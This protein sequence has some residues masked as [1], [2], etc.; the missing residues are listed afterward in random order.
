VFGKAALLSF[1]R[2][3][4]VLYGQTVGGIWEMH[5][6]PFSFRPTRKQHP[7]HRARAAESDAPHV[8][9]DVLHGVQNSHRGYH[10]PALGVDVEVDVL[11]AAVGETKSQ[12]LQSSVRVYCIGRLIQWANSRVLW[13]IGS[14]A[15]DD[16]LDDGLVNSHRPSVGTVT[17]AL[18][19][20]Q[21]GCVVRDPRNR[22]GRG[23]TV[24]G[25]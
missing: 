5:D 25:E 24:R 15:L 14:T 9:V 4:S 20:K 16:V 1:A 7:P 12:S 19:V 6:V 13:T 18:P 3:V 23:I 22:E 2:K 17:G 8:R 11:P 21:R 10:V